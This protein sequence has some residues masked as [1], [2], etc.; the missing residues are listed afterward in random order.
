MMYYLI[1]ITTKFIA[2]WAPENTWGVT[3]LVI[4]LIEVLGGSMF[5]LDIIPYQSRVILQLTPFP[6][7]TYYPIAIL[8]GKIGYS[9]ALRVVA[10]SFI[11]VGLMVVISRHIWNKGLKSYGAY[12]R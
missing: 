9:E 1:N 12:G 2:F 4:V 3:F 7:L 8:T 6:Y 5:P 11:W 10:Q